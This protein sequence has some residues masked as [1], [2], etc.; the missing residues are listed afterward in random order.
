MVGRKRIF[1]CENTTILD[2]NSSWKP[3]NRSKARCIRPN[4][5]ANNRYVE[6]SWSMRLYF[7]FLFPILPSLIV[8]FSSSALLVLTFRAI[9]KAKTFPYFLWTILFH[10]I[11]FI[12]LSSVSNR[13]LWK[14]KSK[15]WKREAMIDK[16]RETLNV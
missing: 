15:F 7:L 14:E 12:D 11:L 4:E 3:V 13:G 6:V 10:S 2:G 16:R 8:P 5:V 1:Q 9:S